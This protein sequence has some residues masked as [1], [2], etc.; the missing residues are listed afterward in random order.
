M[1]ETTTGPSEEHAQADPDWSATFRFVTWHPALHPPQVPFLLPPRYSTT[2]IPVT[3]DQA[4]LKL[5]EGETA[6]DCLE[7]KPGRHLS[8]PLHW[9][10]F[11]TSPAHPASPGAATPQTRVDS[12][13]K[14]KAAALNSDPVAVPALGC[15]ERCCSPL[16]LRTPVRTFD[17]SKSSAEPTHQAHPSHFWTITKPHKPIVVQRQLKFPSFVGFAN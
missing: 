16:V 9:H 15:A 14:V 11:S 5:P 7:L 10:L 12:G 6:F 8:R 4:T 1:K 2:N 3:T 17:W 13:E